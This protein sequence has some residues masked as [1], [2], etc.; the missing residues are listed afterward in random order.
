MAV[1][2]K[3]FLISQLEDGF[4][5][6]V[7]HNAFH[8]GIAH[9]RLLGDEDVLA[10]EFIGGQ[11]IVGEVAVVRIVEVVSSSLI[12]STSVPL[13]PIRLWVQRYFLPLRLDRKRHL[14]CYIFTTE[15]LGTQTRIRGAFFAVFSLA[16]KGE[17]I[18]IASLYFC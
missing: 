2:E 10:A 11:H 6:L 8:Y 4:L 7:R 15:C 5:E 17:I 12:V 9:I 14:F 1:D 16:S 3:L 18:F 13:D